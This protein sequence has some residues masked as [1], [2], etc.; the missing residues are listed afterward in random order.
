MKMTG[1]FFLHHKTD[2]DETDQEKKYSKMFN[3]MFYRPPELDSTCVWDILRNYVKE[4]KPKS[5]TQRNTYLNFKPGHPEYTT[6]CLKKLDTRVVPVLLG[7]RVPRNDS[8][9][10]QLKYAVVGRMHLLT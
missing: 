7:Y 9:S 1:S 5:K 10:D 2:K 8:E 6:H 3:D 4:K